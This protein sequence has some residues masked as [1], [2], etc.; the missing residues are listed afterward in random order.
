M[1]TGQAFTLGIMPLPFL[2]T[3][4][5]KSACTRFAL[6]LNEGVMFTVCNHADKRLRFLFSH[7]IAPLRLTE[8]RI[9]HDWFTFCPTHKHQE[10]NIPTW[11]K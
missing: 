5:P 10:Q 3:A 1:Y 6:G 11:P 4:I 7:A 2:E 8:C 9:K